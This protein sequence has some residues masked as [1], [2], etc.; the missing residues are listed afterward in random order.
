MRDSTFS[1][2]KQVLQEK[3]YL[4]EIKEHSLKRYEAS[5]EEILKHNSKSLE[6]GC[7]G[8]GGG[9]YSEISRKI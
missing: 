5:N 2:K 1:F 7:A 6:Y 8:D 4:K 9:A 3:K